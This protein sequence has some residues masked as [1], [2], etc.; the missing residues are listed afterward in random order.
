MTSDR[1]STRYSVS[2]ITPN[3]PGLSDVKDC[4]LDVCYLA[5]CWDTI[6]TRMN[7][8]PLQR[9]LIAMMILLEA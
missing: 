8:Y 1:Q 2:T 7:A 5:T 3:T 9:L 4:S 6:I